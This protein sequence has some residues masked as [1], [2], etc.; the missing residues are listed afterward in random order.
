MSWSILKMA[1]ALSSGIIQHCIVYAASEPRKILSLAYLVLST[2][3]L[4]PRV[5]HI[6]SALMVVPCTACTSSALT[7]LCIVPESIKT[8]LQYTHSIL[9]GNSKSHNFFERFSPNAQAP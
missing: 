6:G 5:T 2:L 7:K 4:F 9:M 3:V 1:G 8:V